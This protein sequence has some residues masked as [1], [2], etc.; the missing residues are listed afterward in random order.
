MLFVVTIGLLCLGYV[1]WI[2]LLDYCVSVI[3]CC[4]YVVSVGVLCVVCA[5]VLF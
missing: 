4:L 2:S 5:I 1:V 3:L